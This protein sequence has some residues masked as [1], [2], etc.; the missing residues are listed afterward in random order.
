MAKMRRCSGSKTYGIEAHEAPVK[1]FP[2]QPSQKDGLGRMCKT[3]WNQYTAGLAR[4]RKARM[5]DGSYLPRD[6]SKPVAAKPATKAKPAKP[7]HAA[8][9]A[10]GKPA[11]GETPAV[12]T[13]RKAFEKRLARVGVGSDAGQKMLEQAAK[14]RVP[15]GM[16]TAEAAADAV[17]VGEA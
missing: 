16:A 9:M 2:V 10:E 12:T 14:A 15:K 6:A 3:H 17:P 1:D 4:D 8:K 5:A 13:R 11:K 7:S